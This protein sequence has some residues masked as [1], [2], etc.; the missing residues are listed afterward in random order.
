MKSTDKEDLDA[1]LE[2]SG[3]SD[4]DYV[5]DLGTDCMCRPQS[6]S[7]CEFAYPSRA[8]AYQKHIAVHQYRPRM[9]QRSDI[10]EQQAT[11]R[12]LF[13]FGAVGAVIFLFL[14]VYIAVK[15]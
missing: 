15:G 10:E 1:L 6:R 12:L 13:M 14:L 3:M 2:K 8:A 11:S 7:T 5:C 9:K 4:V